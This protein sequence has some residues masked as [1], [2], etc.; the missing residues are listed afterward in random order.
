M[1]CNCI[2]VGACWKC[3]EGQ[4]EES[5]RASTH[6]VGCE[7]RLVTEKDFGIRHDRQ[8]RHFAKYTPDSSAQ[9]GRQRK[10]R[11][12]VCFSGVLKL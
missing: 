12:R 10:G 7:E 3:S 2:G 6:P 8:R 4:Q 11:Y 1:F 5:D 9:E